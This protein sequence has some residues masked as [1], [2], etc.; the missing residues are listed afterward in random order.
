[1][2]CAVVLLMVSTVPN[3]QARKGLFWS[4]IMMCHTQMSYLVTSYAKGCY[5]EFLLHASIVQSEEVGKGLVGGP[6]VKA[7]DT[8]ARSCGPAL[9]T[10]K[11]LLSTQNPH[12]ILLSYLVI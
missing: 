2:H 3:Y 1:M 10:C 7:P 12:P 6:V 8:G 4:D 5:G 11:K 9:E